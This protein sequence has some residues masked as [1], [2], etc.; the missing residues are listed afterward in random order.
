VIATAR[1]DFD[2]DAAGWLP[3]D[4]IQRLGRAPPL[5]LE[6]LAETEVEQL[7]SEDRALAALLRPGHPAEKLVRNL[8][9]LDRLARAV[10][11]SDSPY[12]EA[13]M[14]SQWWQSGDSQRAF[15]RLERRRALH[16][17][18]LQSLASSA[19]LDTSAHAAAPV[20]ELVTTGSLRLL[21]ADRAEFSH[22]VLRD[23]AIASVLFDEPER[24]A[25]LPFNAPLPV[26]LARGIEILAQL[27]VER[28][29]SS[30]SWLQLLGRVS[31][32]GAHGSWRRIVLLALTRSERSLDVLQR[33]ETA[34]VGEHG[35]LLV[36]LA[37]TTVTVDSRPASNLWSAYGVDV[38]KFPADYVVPNGPSWLNLIVWT[39]VVFDRLPHAA[40]PALF[41]LYGRWCAALNGQDAVSPEL[42]KRL[43]TW[44]VEVDKH[45]HPPTFRR[46]IAGVE[47]EE[48]GIPFSTP[49]ET[50]LRQ[51]FLMRCALQPELASAYLR[52]VA[53]YRNNDSVF[54]Q[55]VGFVGGAPRAAPGA[56]ADLF[57]SAL[58]AG[59][60]DS[61]ST[62]NRDVYGYWNTEFFPASPARPPFYELLVNHP[63]EGL[64]LVR[65]VVDYAVRRLSGG[66]V[67]EAQDSIVLSLPEGERAF[68]WVRTYR[69]SRESRSDIVTSGLMALEAWGHMRIERGDP[70]E[71][72]IADLLGLPSACAA[73]LLIAVDVLLS[74][75]PASRAAL[76]PFAANARLLAFDRNRYGMDTITAREQTPWI[77]PEPLSSTSLADLRRKPSRRFPLDAVLD[78][79]GREGSDEMRA[80]MRSLLASQKAELGPPDEQSQAMGDPR[81]AAMSGFN[82]LDS[83]N[84]VQLEGTW[85]YVAPPEEAALLQKLQDVAARGIDEV[86]TY[87][88]LL[89]ALDSGPAQPALLQKAVGWLRGAQ[90]AEKI[91]DVDLE[92]ARWILAALLLRDGEAE[93]RE[94]CALWCREQ[95]QDAAR[96][97]PQRSGHVPQI[98]YNPASIATVGLI[99]AHRHG[100]VSDLATLLQL[101]VRDQTGL[102]SVL[103]AELKGGRKIHG[104]L[105]RAFVRLGITSEIYAV[106]RGVPL[107]HD[108]WRER[109]AALDAAQAEAE[110][111]LREKAIQVEYEWLSGRALEP[112]MPELPEPE[113]PR[114]HRRLGGQAEPVDGWRQ[115]EQRVFALD[116]D[117]ASRWL[118]IATALWAGPDPARLRSL[119]EHAW[120]W[121]AA[122]NGAGAGRD[123]EPAER[124]MQWN[125]AFF[126]GSVDVA[127]GSDGKDFEQ[128][129]L[130]RLSNLADEALFDSIEA[131]LHRLDA[132][133]IDKG[134]VAD[135]QAL[136]VRQR[137]SELLCADR[138]WTW[139]AKGDPS[140]GVAMHLSGAI[141]A[142]FF[143]RY[144][145]LARR[146]G[147]YLSPENVHRSDP[148]LPR[149]AELTK[150]AAGSTFV[151]FAFLDLL[152][153]APRLS[154]LDVLADVTAAWWNRQSSKPGF[155]LEFGVGSRV[156]RWVQIALAS[157]SGV[158]QDDTGRLVAIA[159]ILLRCGVTE[160]KQLEEK[161]LT[162]RQKPSA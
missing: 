84:Y 122:A 121:T 31:G 24:V 86:N 4:A 130:T 99:A 161:V 113:P 79:Y 76:W 64:R 120:P 28:D 126:S 80:A 140:H 137:V 37:K 35:A 138:T 70:I 8:Y 55:I 62:A 100:D 16:D 61:Y 147:C 59:D 98:P 116:A 106:R 119:L 94:T 57:L 132:L 110:R 6:A 2:A 32:Q 87:H 155:W 26:H 89:L 123:V 148:C 151:A 157:A 153:V 90:G 71:A 49:D 60:K 162:L 9:R 112:A 142:V 108:D 39:L 63:E 150:E 139:L 30:E 47:Q 54:R 42:V 107:T 88:H 136:E 43:Y 160:A 53:G 125:A 23:W 38:S 149:L 56:L 72:V 83:A 14:A 82:R 102:A 114:A 156:C 18:A 17:F 13:Q 85:K 65:G 36:E 25:G 118:R 75:W 12:S 1:F 50:N 101:A 141:A 58:R 96:K 92:R 127:A 40:I 29:Q 10:G 104:E 11:H 115:R 33:C 20:E 134:R 159:D 135:A 105:A 152:E 109:Q 45:A 34:L 52:A 97:E 78:E 117:G 5:E 51:T 158:S 21:R 77:R 103:E 145:F 154:R 73:Y 146:P 41:D 46:F 111:S 67:P 27:R 81:F 7:R 68:P 48:E 93:L 124:A 19:P 91:D 143:G 69:W 3:D 144:D 129:V 22:D 95:L 66:R 133:W 131:V 15:G 128:I 44:L 74:N